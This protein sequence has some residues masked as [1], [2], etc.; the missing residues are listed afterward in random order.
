MQMKPPASDIHVS[1]CH[2]L[3]VLLITWKIKLIIIILLYYDRTLYE[4]KF[5]VYIPPCKLI[6]RTFNDKHISL[7]NGIKCLP[8]IR[9]GY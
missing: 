9:L 6:L 7:P 2:L 3:F 4:E 8:G 5:K 1:P